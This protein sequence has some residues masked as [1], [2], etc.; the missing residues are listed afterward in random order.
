M[1]RNAAM[2][3][4][5]QFFGL[6]LCFLSLLASSSSSLIFAELPPESE[7]KSIVHSSFRNMIEAICE[8]VENGRRPVNEEDRE[9][10]IALLNQDITSLQERKKSVQLYS[11]VVTVGTG[12][13]SALYG[14]LGLKNLL[15]MIKFINSTESYDPVQGSLS[16]LVYG[17]TKL[18]FASHLK[19]FA[20]IAG[21]MTQQWIT[22]PFAKNPQ[23]VKDVLMYHKGYEPSISFVSPDRY[24]DNS[25][26]T[27]PLFST[28]SF[29]MS[30]VLMTQAYR[31]YQERKK[32]SE[33]IEA[34]IARDQ[35]II[36][37]LEAAAAK[38]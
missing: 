14:A 33:K 12:A 2:I 25:F 9:L 32:R 38:S 17:P 22:D 23:P 21:Q 11:N 31:S 34:N 4:K 30:G 8:D 29:I 6:I 20:S 24:Y 13:L 19:N 16:K 7:Q 3:K 18:S 5:N 1:Q 10:I 37:K 15:W 36:E 26:V 35:K 27:S 28:F